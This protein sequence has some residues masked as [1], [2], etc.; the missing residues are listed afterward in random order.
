MKAFFSIALLALLACGSQNT[1]T[2]ETSETE[3]IAEENEA[4]PEEA[5]GELEPF[6]ETEVRKFKPSLFDQPQI[7]KNQLYVYADSV[8]IFEDE[9]AQVSL[10]YLNAGDQIKLIKKTDQFDIDTNFFEG[11]WV[12]GKTP[13]GQ[14]VYLQNTYLLP[15]PYDT[16]NRDLAGYAERNLH[17]TD[18]VIKYK[19]L[20]ND[21]IDHLQG[22]EGE[23]ATDTYIYENG[24]QVEFSEDVAS[25]STEMHLPMLNLQQ[26]VLF[27]NSLKKGFEH[28]PILEIT[29]G[30]LPTETMEDFPNYEEDIRITVS[31]KAGQIVEIEYNFG[32]EMHFVWVRF[33]TLDSRIL[34]ESGSGM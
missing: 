28:P 19:R 3:E 16:N 6:V 10:G 2:S 12:R 27:Y 11:Y 30:K 20:K 33:K 29:N 32:Y 34:I 31:K 24:I 7:Q 22:L 25:A 1:Q 8:E 14:Q 17:L 4:A 5:E 13:S 15:L 18:S 26:A 21:D 9:A 23:S